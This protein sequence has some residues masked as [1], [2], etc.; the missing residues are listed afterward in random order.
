MGEGEEQQ[1]SS[2]Q[3]HF[4]E[5]SGDDSGFYGIPVH[6][7]DYLL[8]REE[9]AVGALVCFPFACLAFSEKKAMHSVCYSWIYSSIRL[10]F[11]SF[12]LRIF[13]VFILLP[14]AIRITECKLIIAPCSWIFCLCTVGQTWDFMRQPVIVLSTAFPV[15][16][17]LLLVLSLPVLSQMSL[18]S[19]VGIPAVVCEGTVSQ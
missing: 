5:N 9:M 17:V 19:S 11:S 4:K 2:A 15:K 12:L 6:S 8:L 13:S 1:L 14:C 16:P 10:I 3:E 7:G 18:L